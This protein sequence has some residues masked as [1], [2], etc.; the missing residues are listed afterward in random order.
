VAL[1]KKRRRPFSTSTVNGG[2][3][4]ADVAVDHAPILLVQRHDAGAAQPQVVL[5]RQRAPSTW[6]W[7]A[8]PRSCQVQLGTLR[9][10][11]GAQRVALAE[12]AARGVGD[13]PA[14]V[15]VVAVDDELRPCP[16]ASGPAPRR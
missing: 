4:V 12:Q 11:G 2:H 8:W 16:R 13:D 9:Q 6:R 10:A 7:S 3:V 5:Q 1:A 14:A 15:G